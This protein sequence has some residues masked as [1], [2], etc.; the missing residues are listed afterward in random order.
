MSIY[1]TA[2]AGSQ[3]GGGTGFSYDV[4]FFF[5]GSLGLLVLVYSAVQP[6]QDFVTINHLPVVLLLY[7]LKGSSNFM[8]A[9]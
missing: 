6:E 4:G 3:G 5:G 9:Q 1:A 2:V 7:T 8:K